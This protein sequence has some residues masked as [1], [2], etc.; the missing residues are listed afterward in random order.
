MY[1]FVFVMCVEFGIC[2]IECFKI[3][4]DINYVGDGYGILIL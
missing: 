2:L 1:A 3:V 4:V